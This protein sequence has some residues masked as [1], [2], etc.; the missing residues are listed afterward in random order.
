MHR[1]R[2]RPVVACVDID[3]ARG[4]APV[5]RA[6]ELSWTR[7]AGRPRSPP[8]RRGERLEGLRRGG[9][10][11]LVRPKR[12]A[13]TLRAI[14]ARACP[15]SR[16]AKNLFPWLRH[17]A[18][19]AEPT[20][21]RSSTAPGWWHGRQPRLHDGRVAGALSAVPPQR[22][23]GRMRIQDAT[24]CR[25][26]FRRRSAGGSTTRAWARIADGCCATWAG[27]ELAPSRTAWASRSRDGRDHRTVKATRARERDR[28]DPRRRRASG[29]PGGR[30][31]GQ[32]GV[33]EAVTLEFQAAIGRPIPCRTTAASRPSR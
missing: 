25:I 22:A 11:H 9:R 18:L 4:H 2:R 16:P 21:S 28:A 15:S 7:P 13:P 27:R 31:G 29:A 32:V 12:G 26:P 6:P 19:A 30:E 33:F 17:A 8:H 5:R 3:R 23:E 1:A 20:R 14:L 10:V 24:P